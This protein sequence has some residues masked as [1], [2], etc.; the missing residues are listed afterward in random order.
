LSCS[1]MAAMRAA[2]EFAFKGSV[3]LT[4]G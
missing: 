3:D 4:K 1:M 2:I